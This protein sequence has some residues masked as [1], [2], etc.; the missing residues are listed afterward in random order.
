MLKASV[1]M[2][3]AML[4]VPLTA[5]AADE[6]I[7]IKSIGDLKGKWTG[8]GGAGPFGQTKGSDLDYVIADDGT[9]KGTLTNRTGQRFDFQGSLEPKADGSVSAAG[10]GGTGTW[11]LFDVNGTRVIRMEGRNRN[12]G[13]STWGEIKEQK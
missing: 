8:I 13:A 1:V 5:L 7:P 2:L 12:T 3:V 10:P 11:K 4:L 9:F 6:Q